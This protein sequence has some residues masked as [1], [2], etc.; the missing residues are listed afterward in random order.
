MTRV[1]QIMICE[2]NMF[3]DN[4]MWDPQFNSWRLM[5]AMVPQSKNTLPTYHVRWKADQYS[6]PYTALFKDLRS[7]NPRTETLHIQLHGSDFANLPMSA[8]LRWLIEFPPEW[9]WFLSW[10]PGQVPEH[11]KDQPRPST[12]ASSSASLT[13]PG[14]LSWGAPPGSWT[15][16]LCHRL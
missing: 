13:T 2:S 1:L 5:I 10:S 12:P 11:F 6:P 8:G 15:G 16:H 14:P 7:R 4:L 3:K 9:S